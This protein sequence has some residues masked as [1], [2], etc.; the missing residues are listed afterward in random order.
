MIVYWKKGRGHSH[1]PGQDKDVNDQ[2]DALA[3]AGALHR[4]SWTFHALP[5]NPSVAA[6]TH[7]SNSTG[8]HTPASSHIAL[9]PQFAADDLLTTQTVD[10]SL[11]TMAAHISYP[12][13]HSISN[14]NLNTFLELCTLNS[15]KHMLHFRDGMLT[16]VP[17]PLTAPKLVFSK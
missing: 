13:T 9:S 15:I 3:K 10:P 1:Q 6:V 14:S 2:T 11:R 7:H 12:L 17:V 5:P 8:V 16:Y 4:E